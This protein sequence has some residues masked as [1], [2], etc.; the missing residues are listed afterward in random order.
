MH[1]KM[2]AI[3]FL[4]FILA[5]SLCACG[6]QAKFV[7]VNKDSKTIHAP[8]VINFENQSKK[9]ETYL[10]DF[11]DGITSDSPNPSHKYK[12]SGMYEVVLTAKKGKRMDEKTKKIQISAPE[13]C[14][15][16][17]STS[18]GVMIVELYDAT[19]KH[20][21]NFIKLVEEGFY[22]DLI[23]HRVINGFM[24][25]GGDPESRNARP[26][27]GLGSGGPGYTVEAEFVDT[28][29]H[30]KGALAAARLSDAVNPDKESSGS[31]FYIVQ[32]RNLGEG[33]LVRNE[34][35]KGFYY[36]PAQKEAYLEYGGT[37]F[38]DREYTVF[39][40]V[41]EG[42]EVIDAIAAV[43]TNSSSRPVEDIKM[44]IRVIK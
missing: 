38:L 25:Q 35:M 33:E 1:K 5:V 8:A 23:F 16:E 3:K 14:L 22:N 9:A 4:F 11:G 36:A 21:D 2:N 34:T 44:T 42:M 39:G 20:R 24:I 31:Q 15:V 10:W 32:G 17:I 12:S 26:N 7:V 37:P 27:A 6:P 30:K 13:K 19:P 29:V 41:V 28:L 40:Q 18:M 43:K